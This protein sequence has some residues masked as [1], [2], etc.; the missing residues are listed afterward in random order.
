MNIRVVIILKELFSLADRL[1]LLREERGLTQSELARQLGL[2]RS[3]VNGWESGLAVPSTSMIIELAKIFHVTTDYLLGMENGCVFKAEHLTTKE[4][5][6]IAS[7]IQ[8]LEQNNASKEG[9]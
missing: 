1:R 9:S 7:L 2:S 5:S 4:A 6:I 3:S 8:C